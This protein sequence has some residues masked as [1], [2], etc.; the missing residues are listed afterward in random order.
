MPTIVGVFNEPNQV[1]GAVRQLRGRGFEDLVTYSPAP[2][3][4][5]DDAV[6]D[7]PS[8]VRLFTLI[9]GLAGVTTGYAMTLWM[10][11]DWQI[12]LGGRSPRSRPTRSSPSSS[13]SFSAAS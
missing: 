13:P 9:G 10:A 2:F 3:A 12:M 4:E 6:I 7:K 1:V 5:I 11:N 8:N